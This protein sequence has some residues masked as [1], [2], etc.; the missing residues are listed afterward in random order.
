MILPGTKYK[1]ILE[2]ERLKDVRSQGLEFIVSLEADP[3]TAKI[4]IEPI[5]FPENICLTKKELNEN[6]ELLTDFGK[7]IYFYTTQDEYGMFSNFS[8]HGI[9]VDNAFYPTVEHYYQ[10]CKFENEEY[11]ERIRTCASP[12]RASELGKSKEQVIKSNWNDIKIDVMTKSIR[13]KF[14]QNRQIRE[15]L[16]LTENK[17]L[18]ENSPYDNFWG[19]G[20]IGEGLNYLGTVLMRVRRNL[21]TSL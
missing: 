21:Q 16:L 4:L 6:C 3:R 2:I 7:A 5:E 9:T 14:E 17:L 15:I 10:A 8:D 19:I 12:K 11:Q 18:I 13:L 20:R 1:I